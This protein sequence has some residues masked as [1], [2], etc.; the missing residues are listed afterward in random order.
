MCKGLYGTG[1]VSLF[2]VSVVHQFLPFV[3]QSWR[4][5]C[6]CCLICS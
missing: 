6:R 2:K 5:W 3:P 4:V 1:A